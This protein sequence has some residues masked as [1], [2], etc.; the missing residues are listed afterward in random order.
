MKYSWTRKYNKK[1]TKAD[2]PSRILKILA[3]NRGIDADQIKPF[4]KPDRP[5]KFSASQVGIDEDEL[6]KAVR[7]IKKTGKKKKI[8][9]YG[10]YDIDGLTGTAIL[11]E[12]LWRKGYNVLPYIPNRDVGYGLKK[13]SLSNLLKTHPDLE[14]VITV[15]NGIV[16][17]QAVNFAKKQGLKV[18]I[19]DHH[20][21]SGRK[22][23]SDAVVHT[24]AIAGCGVAWFLAREFGYQLIDLAA[25]GTIG[26]LLPV[27]GPNRSF[28]KFGLDELARSNRPGIRALKKV[29]GLEIGR[30]LMTWQVSYL[31]GPRLNAAG[32]ISDPMTALRL[33]CTKD[34]KKAFR[35]AQ[36]LDSLNS[37][38]QDVM[39]DGVDLAKQ[40][41]VQKNG[42]ILASSPKFHPGIIGLIA[43][44]L[45]EELNCPAIII[46]EGEK[47]SKASARSVSGVDIVKLI[48]QSEEILIDVGGHP[49]AAGFSVE[50]G[51]IKKLFHCLQVSA[52]SIIKKI[53]LI[54]RK[55]YDFEIDFSLINKRFYR[56]IEKFSPFGV[57]NP[58]PVFCLTNARVVDLQTVGAGKNH[59]KFWLD[60]PQTPQI[61]RILSEAKSDLTEAIGFQWGS[62]AK[63][64]LPGDMI[65]LVFD[66][67][68]NTWNG[69]ESLQL[70]VKDLDLC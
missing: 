49:M 11:W 65:K 43:G 68:L 64:I 23:K 36:K 29:S 13:E 16:A 9:I 8:I 63:K 69:K 12:A 54:P 6:Q 48:R 70:K 4:I 44:K 10:D 31:L 15:D 57:G 52:K 17:Y 18:I 5:K 30:E 46:S 3:A 40:I 26:D 14:M 19:T 38:R 33:L 60:D 22:L 41:L 51:K 35:L 59:L 56:L 21:R 20:L 53:D 27:I 24:T 25:I 1:V 61:E 34:E 50:T 37:Q 47:I 67:N 28:V 62:W 66:L 42:L 32:R 55:S 7:L 58:R 2:S 39:Q 45:T